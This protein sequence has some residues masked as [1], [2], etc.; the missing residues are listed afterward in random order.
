MYDNARPVDIVME[1]MSVSA[2]LDR[3]TYYAF[4]ELLS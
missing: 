4:D 2:D 1:M 3:R